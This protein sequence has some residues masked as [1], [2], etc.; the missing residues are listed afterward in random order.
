VGLC[1]YRVAQ[2]ALRHVAGH[3][4][5]RQAHVAL[6]RTAA[7]L[8]L[9]STDDGQGCERTAAR[10]RGGLGLSSLDARG[11]LVGGSVRSHTPRPRGTT[12]RVQGPLGG[13]EEAPHDGTARR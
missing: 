13:R 4:G 7:G 6:Q 5:A 9:T 2:E 1:L 12:R 11:R 3:A 10:R 8:E